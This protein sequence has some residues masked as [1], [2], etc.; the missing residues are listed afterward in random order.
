MIL[1]DFHTH[2]TFCDGDNSPEEMVLSA[3]QKGIQKLGFSVHAYVDFDDCCVK[4][5][6]IENYKKEIKRLREKYKDEIQIFCGVEM[7]YHSSMEL[8]GFDYVIGSVHY[9][10]CGEE[11]IAVDLD[12]KSLKYAADKY[13]GSDMYALCE[14]YYRMVAD[15][16]NKF[17]VDIIGHFDLITKF[18]EKEILFDTNN[19]RYINATKSAIDKLVKRG[20][21][22]EINTGAISRGYRTT[23]YPSFELTEY[24]AK[25]G[26]KF[27]LSSDSHN[28]DS[29]CLQFDKWE[30]EYR[31]LGADIITAKF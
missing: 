18:C 26:G 31:K 5:E 15:I 27:I 25:K 30:K 28:K 17:K 9:L 16:P 20:I 10:K 7:D 22:F 3:I 1:E 24:I 23:P 13:F 21:P 8:D 12:T 4:K 19:P 6:E 2:T 14:E 29:L 11:Y